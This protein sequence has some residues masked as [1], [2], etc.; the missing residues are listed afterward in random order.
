MK[1]FRFIAGVALMLPML[2]TGA[3]AEATKYEILEVSESVE[4]NAPAAKVWEVVGKWE[5]MLWHPAFIKSTRQLCLSANM[6]Q[7]S[8]LLK[9][10]AKQL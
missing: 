7:R 4:I 9:K 3:H 5:D 6:A 8:L 1:L 10:P 2:A